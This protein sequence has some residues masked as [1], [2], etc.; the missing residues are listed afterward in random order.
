MFE[1]GCFPDFPLTQSVYC[2]KLRRWDIPDRLQQSGLIKPCQPIQ[3]FQFQRPDGFPRPDLVNQ[4]SLV[5]TDLS[6]IVVPIAS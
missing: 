6:P 3:G 1:S 2:L 4:F 5:Q